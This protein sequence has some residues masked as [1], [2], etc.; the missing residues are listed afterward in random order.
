[1]RSSFY[2]N[3]VGSRED[4][5]WASASIW[6]LDAHQASAG[7]AAGKGQSSVHHRV[8]RANSKCHHYVQ[9][10]RRKADHP[11]LRQC[12]CKS[13]GSF[14]EPTAQDLT[15]SDQ[16]DISYVCICW[17]RMAAL[18]LCWSSSGG[19]VQRGSHSSRI[20]NPCSVTV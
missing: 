20:A 6:L 15:E 1:M 16:G 13:Y 3:S 17:Q 11:N 4:C 9:R 5:N 18:A 7:P 8:D 19:W 2:P 10:K 14:Q 12:S